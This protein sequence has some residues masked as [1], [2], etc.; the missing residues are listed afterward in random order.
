M[1]NGSLKN[2]LFH[3]TRWLSP[4]SI[5]KT[6]YD[7]NK[8]NRLNLIIRVHW[9]ADSSGVVHKG[10]DNY[11][12]EWENKINGKWR[13]LRI[14]TKQEIYNELKYEGWFSDIDSLKPESGSAILK[15]AEYGQQDGDLR[16]I[17]YSYREWDLINNKEVK[18]IRQ[19]N[20]PKQEII[21]EY[22][23]NKSNSIS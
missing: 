1:G 13:L 2:T 12:L 10:K 14:I 18:Y 15:I 16:V 6:I 7:E 3:F 21:K 23:T 20:Y 17:N 9:W 11:A 19:C 4:K 8:N 22:L 5:G